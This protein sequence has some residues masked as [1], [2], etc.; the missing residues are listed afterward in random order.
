[1]TR[2]P[3]VAE[4]I[5]AIIRS[6]SDVTEADRQIAQPVI[7]AIRSTPLPRMTLAKIDGGQA[8]PLPD[9]LL[10]YER[11]ARE[12]AAVAWVLWNSGLVTFFS[13]FMSPELRSEVFGHPEALFCQSTRPM[14][15]AEKTPEG[16]AISGRWSL[17][18]GCNHA[19]WAFL[20]CF[21]QQDGSPV[22]EPSGMPRM[23]IAALPKNQFET[24]DT[25][26]SSGLRGTG[27][28]DVIVDR[29]N[30]PEHR[31]FQI[32]PHQPRDIYDRV[33]IMSA[34]TAI[35]A[36]QVLGVTQA[37]CDHL[38]HR[39]KTEI[40]PG[41][42]PDLR[43]RPETLVGLASHWA[44]LNA[45]RLGLHAA[46]GKVWQLAEAGQSVDEAP[47][48]ELYAASMHAMAIAKSAMADLHAFAGTKALYTASPIERRNRDLQAMLRHIVAQPSM[49]A[50]VG[51]SLF[52]AAPEWPPYSV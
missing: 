18:S 22:I 2:F 50:D 26:H 27:S 13:R 36:A 1:M 40:T 41:P 39:G 30:V 23:L 4:Q 34:V 14:G 52:G 31:I 32:G 21:A 45:A 3:D 29:V 5:S 7:D 33:P 49:L 9:V 35:F 37:V 44:A 24:V 42:M 47:I 19:D 43:D 6:H 25:W 8:M 16:H 10:V 12:D 48:T 15:T 46:A 20:T 28:H 11:L 51:R 38:R 17:V